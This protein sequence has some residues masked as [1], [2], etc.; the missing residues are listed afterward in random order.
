VWS[1]AAAVAGS[2]VDAFEVGDPAYLPL[3][4]LADAKDHLQN[5][6]GVGST[7]Y[8]EKI[9]GLILTTTA[10]AE[11]YTNR[12]LA[13]QTYVQTVSGGNT[14]ILLWYPTVLSITSIVESGV[15]LPTTAYVVN[16]ASGIVHRG[17]YA[18]TVP[19]IIGVDNVTV[20][21]VAGYPNPPADLTFGI[22]EILRWLWS[23]TQEA[24]RPSR[25]QGEQG[26][27]ADAVPKWLMRPLQQY[28]I[29]GL[30]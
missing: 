4:G 30:G 6:G 29:P 9:R 27:L 13:R 15:T 2:Y 22:K 8:D 14:Y 5:P 21:Y 20:T 17:S 28:R 1:G 11:N 26:L 7:A 12:A 19:W 23:N 24:N 25:S 10:L 3:I 18:Y 16:K